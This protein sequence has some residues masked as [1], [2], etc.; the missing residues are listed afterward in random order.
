MFSLFYKFR[1]HLCIAVLLPGILYGQSV[2]AQTI[3]DTAAIMEQVKNAM[4]AISD[5][6][7]MFSK[8]ELVG[9]RIIREDNIILKV[10]RPGSFY[11]KW[12]EGAHKGRVAI[13]VEGRNNNKIALHLNG[14]LGFLTV[15]IDPNGKEAFKDN[16]HSITEADMVSITGRF[17]ANCSRGLTDPEC[18][19]V[20]ATLKGPDTLEL[21]AVFPSGK[22]YYAHMAA[23]TVDRRSWLPMRLTCYGW[24][25]EFLEEYRFEDIKI[26]PGLTGK[27]FKG[28]W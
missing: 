8:H 20:V 26:N 23:M 22:D 15:T 2:Q 19:P 21:K 3:D 4:A 13:Y 7:C 6:I 10:K 25:N 18:S 1:R 24:N 14:L 17:L 28:D 16:R 11:L 12:T 27:D 5:Y 9:D